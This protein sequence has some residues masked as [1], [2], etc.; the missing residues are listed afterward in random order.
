LV[1]S[2]RLQS[3]RSRRQR[4]RRDREVT[5]GL[6]RIAFPVYGLPAAWEARRTVGGSSWGGPTGVVGVTLSH[7][8][9]DGA[10][11]LEVRVTTRFA[12]TSGVEDLEEEV[13]IDFGLRSPD[14]Q[15]S[16]RTRLE[17]MRM[18]IPVEGERT[19]FE[20]IAGR[21]GQWGAVGAVGEVAVAIE[22]RNF[23]MADV[24]LERVTDIE[25][26]LAGSL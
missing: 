22:V 10:R 4:E 9:G 11:S 21:E 3:W 18:R 25:P 8:I 7:E 12:H 17:W 19:D 1:P 23:A 15:G 14:E 26:Y 5:E 24:V 20:V 6:R 13:E 2:S 16:D